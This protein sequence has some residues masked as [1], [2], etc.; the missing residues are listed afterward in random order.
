M[1]PLPSLKKI[2]VFFSTLLSKICEDKP[3]LLLSIFLLIILLGSFIIPQLE[4]GRLYGVDAY[5]HIINTD[6]MASS[7]GLNDFYDS[8]VDIVEDPSEASYINYPFG[9]WLFGA[10]ITKL[11]GLP[12]ITT[13][14]FFTTFSLLVLVG[15]FYYYSSTWLDLRAQKVLAVLFLLSMPEFALSLMNYSPSIFVLPFLFILLAIIFKDTVNWKLLPIAL[16]S[17][18][19]IIISHVGTFVFLLGFLLGFFLLYCLFWGKFSKIVYLAILSVLSIY[20]I[21][22]S[23]FPEITNQYLYSSTKF[24]LPGNVLKNTF[25]FPLPGDIIRVFYQGL[26]I[27]HNFSYVIILAAIL[28]IGGNALTYIHRRFAQFL[29]HDNN[30]LPA[31]ILPIQ[32]LSHSVFA[33]P[34]WIGPVHVIFSVFGFFHL[35]EKGKCFLITA[36]LITLVPDLLQA[37]QGISTLTGTLREISYLPII[38]PITA[39]LGFWHILEYLQDPQSKIKTRISSV[40]WVVVCL[41][42]IITPSLATTYYDPAISGEDY[43]ITGLKWLGENGDHSEKVV[44][45]LLRPVGLYTQMPIG[46]HDLNSG[47]ETKRFLKLLRDLYFTTEGQIENAQEFRRLYGV[48]YIISSD[49]ILRYFGG[50]TENLTIDSNPALSKIYASNE[51]RIYEIQSFTKTP[52]PKLFTSD[53][54]SITYE[55][56]NYKI[57]SDYYKVTLGAN[58]PVLKRFGPRDTDYLNYGFFIENFNVGG[59]GLPSGED[60]FKLEDLTFSSDVKDNQI[61]YTTVLIDPKSQLPVGTFFVRYTFYPD[62]IKREYILSNDWLVAESSP[63]ITVHYSISSLSWLKQFVVTNGNTRLERKTVVY[64]DSINKNI[65]V[66]DFYLHEGDEGMYISFAGISPQ[67]SS[68][69]YSGSISNRSIISL[70]QSTPVKPGASFL[71]TQF[72]SFGSEAVAK[73]VIQSREGIELVPYPDGIIPIMLSG[74][75]ST[76]TSDNVTNERISAA[77]AVLINNS[78]PYSDVEPEMVNTNISIISSQRTG[79]INYD[80]YYTQETNLMNLPVYSTNQSVSYPGFM[81]YA[82]NYNLDTLNILS[83]YKIPFIVS[84]QVNAPVN[85]VY[86]KGYR[87]PQIAYLYSEPTGVV[88]FP[89]SLPKSD[90]L[91]TKYFSPEK[92]FSDW[93]ATIDGAGEND[94][95]VLFFIRAEDIGNPEYNRYFAELFSYAKEKGLTFTSPAY[96]ADHVM[97]LHNISFSG[98]IDVDTATLQVNNANNVTA[99]NVTFKVTLPVLTNGT[100]RATGGDIIR[101]KSVNNRSVVYIRTEIP[102]EST[103]TIFIEP[104]IP[105]KS[106]QIRIPQFPIEGPIEITIMDEAGNPLQNMDVLVDATYYQTNENGIARVDLKR[107]YH[108]VTINIAGY[109]KYSSLLNVKGRIFIIPNEISKILIES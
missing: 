5:S 93:K 104:D 103:K 31:V 12:T 27:D 21:V 37:S 87:V 29:I 85:N 35:K 81:P 30:H 96:I 6:R 20:V 42:I 26:I 17:I 33:S 84:S 59:T 106:L 8:S 32:N 36:L 16:I 108:K 43:V 11:T 15:A 25:H 46:E 71:S 38:I 107:G 74:Y 83:R 92:I 64:E 40:C 105:R 95:M 97:Q 52:A 23:W 76:S 45:W 65:N 3:F 34:I 4:F 89:I 48:K 39:T 102:A 19:I 54:L 55:G 44:G 56:G 41:V 49:K 82:L 24:L 18:F 58:T 13:V 79:G 2:Q 69:T 86:I 62:V 109:E 63:Q 73:R 77:Y 80:D 53:N 88:L 51:F 101:I 7:W 47:T 75:P 66:D 78:I 72:I 28:Y 94:E 61:T 70:S 67:P 60:Q 9:M 91:G 57:D 22:I 14:F 1:Q 10:T 99:R 90:S 50:T 68:I 98:I 100:Y